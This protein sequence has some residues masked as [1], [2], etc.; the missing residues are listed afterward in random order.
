MP[1]KN[2]TREDDVDAFY[3][4]YNRGNNKMDIFL[5][6]SDYRYFEML[7]A[8]SLSPKKVFDKFSRQYSNFNGEVHIYAYCLMPN[9]FH[10]LLHQKDQK[11]IEKFM[12]SIATAYTM[13]FNRKH[14]RRGSLYESMYKSVRIKSD[15]QLIHVSRYI[16]LNPINYLTWDYSSY[17]DY[18]YGARDWITSGF[19]LG[20]FKSPKLYADFTA[21]YEDVKRANKE[22]YIEI[23][24]I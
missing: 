7:L 4:V 18:M 3:H 15:E 9:H 24:D 13:Y 10:F 22:N 20:M 17:S 5:D 23:G 19:I 21:D 14:N 1:R 11:Q 16:H 12:S 6:D 8:R 2:T